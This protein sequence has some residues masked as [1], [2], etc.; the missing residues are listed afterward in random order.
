MFVIVMAEE[1][2]L[3]GS[4][5]FAANPIVPIENI[6]ANVNFDMPLILYPFDDVIAFKAQHSSLKTVQLMHCKHSDWRFWMTQCRSKLYSCAVIITDS[7][8]RESRRL[9]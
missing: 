4:Q 2:G 1:K 3:L 8:N 6:V 9:C 5:Y 7:F